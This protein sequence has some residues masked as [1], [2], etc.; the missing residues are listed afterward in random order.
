MLLEPEAS[1]STLT[2]GRAVPATFKVCWVQPIS[3]PDQ[4][5]SQSEVSSGIISETEL[6]ENASAADASPRT[7]LYSATQATAQIPKLDSGALKGENARL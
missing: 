7:A 2:L 5:L 4:V 6:R 1:I 3:G